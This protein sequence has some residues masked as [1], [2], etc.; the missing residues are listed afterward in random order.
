VVGHIKVEEAVS[1][2]LEVPSFAV[3]LVDHETVVGGTVVRDAVVCLDLGKRENVGNSCGIVPNFAIAGKVTD[4]VRAGSNAGVTL[5][6]HGAV[7]DPNVAKHLLVR[8]GI[9]GRLVVYEDPVLWDGGPTLV[10]KGAGGF[11][12]RNGLVGHSF[13]SPLKE[14]EIHISV[15]VKI[16]DVEAGVQVYGTGSLG[17]FL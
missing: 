8:K 5:D 12:G 11:D 10:V 4:Q 14:G 6:V 9:Y 13:F 3:R 17:L 2:F 15:I 16:V 7:G 1:G